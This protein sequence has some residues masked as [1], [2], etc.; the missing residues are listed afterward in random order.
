MG[1]KLKGLPYLVVFAPNGKRTDLLGANPKKLLAASA[2]D[3]RRTLVSGLVGLA[4]VSRRP[5]AG[6]SRLDRT[7]TCRSA[8]P[9]RAPPEPGAGVS[10]RRSRP[11]RSRSST[12][13]R[14]IPAW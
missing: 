14:K 13:N 2:R 11:R 4:L 9:C 6:L 12:S 1:A 8:G 3:E 5:S 7:R 10:A